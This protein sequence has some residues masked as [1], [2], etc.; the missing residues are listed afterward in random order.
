LLFKHGHYTI[1][2]KLKHLS[3]RAAARTIKNICIAIGELLDS[4]ASA[5][6]A[7]HVRNSGYPST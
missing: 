6:C 3:R 5:E 4:F 7:N 2:A 1:F